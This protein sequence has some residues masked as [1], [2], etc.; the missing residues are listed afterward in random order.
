[1]DDHNGDVEEFHVKTCTSEDSAI[2]VALERMEKY[3]DRIYDIRSE[4]HPFMKDKTIHRVVRI[5]EYE[6]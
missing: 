3:P 4:P 5:M 1:M 6:W 2:E